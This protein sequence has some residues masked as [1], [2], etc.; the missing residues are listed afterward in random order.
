MKLFW[1]LLI[2][3]FFNLELSYAQDKSEDF[4]QESQEEIYKK[5]SENFKQGKYRSTIL[6]LDT[7][8]NRQGEAKKLGKSKL[9][10]IYYWKGICHNRLQE[11]PEAI[12]SFDQ[13]LNYDYSP[14]DLNYEYGQALFASD[15]LQEARLQFKESLRK[16]FKRAVSLYYIAF[17]SRELGI[18]RSAS[19]CRNT[20]WRYLS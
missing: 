10:L 8:L 7:V 18:K 6:E 3:C 9:G 5:A 1:C 12:S 15:K 16:K 19:G 2:I 13:A 11:F 4:E 14:V 20:D 17:I